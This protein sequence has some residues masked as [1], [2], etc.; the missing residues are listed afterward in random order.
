MLVLVA[1]LPLLF[2]LEPHVFLYALTSIFLKFQIEHANYVISR[3]A[4]HVL[5]QQL[6]AL[7]AIKGS[8]GIGLIEHAFHNPLQDGISK[9][10]IEQICPATQLAYH[11]QN[12]Q[13]QTAQSAH[14]TLNI[15]SKLTIKLVI[16]HVL[17]NFIIITIHLLVLR[18]TVDA[19]DA[20]ELLKL[21]AINAILSIS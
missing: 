21:N 2:Y 1:R 10:R 3:L 6:I 19:V 12:I 7:I 8:I 15:I 17:F 20:S 16:H 11:V 9:S 18:V 14:K 13:P 5:I 4:F